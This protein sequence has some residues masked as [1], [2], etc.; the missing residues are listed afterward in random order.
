MSALNMTGSWY[1]RF[2]AVLFFLLFTTATLSL[3]G[4]DNQLLMTLHKGVGMLFIPL[5]LIHLIA[6]IHEST[7]VSKEG[8]LAGSTIYRNLNQPL[9]YKK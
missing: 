6:S 5:F 3:V 8:Y 4:I 7:V 9:S 1:S 2:M